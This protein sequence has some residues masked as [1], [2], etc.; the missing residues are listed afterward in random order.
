MECVLGKP[1]RL[2][3]RRKP[4]IP[5]RRPEHYHHLHNDAGDRTGTVVL[6]RVKLFHVRDDIIDDKFLVDTGKLQPVSRLGGIS[7]GRTKSTFESPVRTLPARRKA[8]R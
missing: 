6:G 7:Y 8:V 5:A 1:L 4:L 3:L 2:P